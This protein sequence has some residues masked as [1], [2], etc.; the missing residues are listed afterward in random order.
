MPTRSRFSFVALVS[1]LIAI[2]I[3]VVIVAASGLW[4]RISWWGL[5]T[6]FAVVWGLEL[7]AVALGSRQRASADAIRWA[8]LGAVLG[9]GSLLLAGFGLFGARLSA[10]S[11]SSFTSADWFDVQW[12]VHQKLAALHDLTLAAS[13]VLVVPFLLTEATLWWALRGRERDVA[14]A[15]M[16]AAHEATTPHVLEL[17]GT[18]LLFAAGAA[19]L[20]GSYVAPVPYA[21]PPAQARL[22][23]IQHE[24]AQHHWDNACGQLRTAVVN[25]GAQTVR[26]ELPG[27]SKL[28]RLCVQGRISRLQ[29]AGVGCDVLITGDE[30]LAA[31]AGG[32]PEVVASCERHRAATKKANL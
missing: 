13:V 28:A 8:T 9:A 5:S 15:D 11:V 1:A 19:V 23:R 12:A 3:A 10:E 20:A 24:A 16:Q 17:A 27:A 25:R 4:A 14:S 32:G 7:S 22:Q 30:P 29:K 21:Q 2:A 31:L 26:H 18:L 6:L